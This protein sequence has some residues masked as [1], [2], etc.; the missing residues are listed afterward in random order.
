MKVYHVAGKGGILYLPRGV[1]NVASLTFLDNI[2]IG[3][4]L[5][6]GFILVSLLMLSV[7]IYGSFQ[8]DRIY[9]NMDQMYTENTVPMLAIANT[10]VSLNSIR[11]L[12]FRSIAVPEEFA[13]DESRMKNETVLIESLLVEFEDHEMSPEVAESFSLFKEQWA[14]YKA[15]A[16]EVF[17]LEAA[18]K[19]GE[20]KVSIMNGGR[21]ANARRATANTFTALKEANLREAEAKAIASKETKE[22]SIFIMACLAAG[23]LLLSLLFAFFLTRS[24]T[25][26]L[27][28][29]VEQFTWMSRGIV[30]RRLN[31]DR[32]DELGDLARLFDQFSD[33]LEHDVTGAMRQIAA[34]DVSLRLEPKGDDD[35][36]T[37]ALNGTISALTSVIRELKT[38]SARAAGGDLSVR[39][40]PGSLEG[41]YHE[42]IVGFNATLDALIQPVH[43]AMRLSQEYAACNY[44]ARFSDDVFAGGD[45][46]AFREALDAIGAEISHALTAINTRMAGLAS[47]AGNASSGIEAVRQGAS[48]IADNADQTKKT[49]AE[50]EEGIVQ[51]LKA[52][53][54][55]TTTVASVTANVEAVA[56][57]GAEADTLAQTGI[58]HAA[59]AEQGMEQIRKTS[60]ETG[61]IIAEIQKQMEE[62]SKIIGI[63]TS[64][65]DQTSLLALNAAIEAARAGEAGRGFAVVAEE[66]KSL[67][68]QAGESA[69]QITSMIEVLDTKTHAAVGAIT[70]A[71]EAVREGTEAVKSTLDVFNQLTGSVG[72]I[73]THMESVAGASEEQA[74]SFEEITASVQEMS[75]LVRQTAKDA[76]TSSETAEEALA[77]VSQITG[78]ITGIEDVVAETNRE[79]NRFTLRT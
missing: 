18:G 65:S 38:L 76:L 69:H 54:D 29:I 8:M 9:G 7:G 42:I 66:V 23:A 44:N 11:A 28:R 1:G 50:S 2:H 61:T 58:R 10:E 20:A 6:V 47:N 68:T 39:G 52:M 79:M 57:A 55:M 17:S 40:D 21:H 59:E 15:A 27:D 43:E 64:I 51:V 34:G 13:S 41:S 46:I 26:P 70:D 30:S 53:E 25:R 62:I 48:S 35:Q 36:I 49:A 72:S 78:I 67:A 63:I 74:A 45:F 73:S 16:Q 56:R 24:I 37:P 31:L 22:S 4:K 77:M 14:E 12:V 32:K 3:K 75:S 60:E 71:G 33:Y 19:L 5:I